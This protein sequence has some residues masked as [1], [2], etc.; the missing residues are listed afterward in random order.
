MIETSTK[1]RRRAL[2]LIL[3]LLAACAFQSSALAQYIQQGPKLVG[4]GAID[5]PDGA[6]QGQA[7]AL[8]A[9]GNT[10]LVGGGWDNNIQGAVWIWTRSGGAWTQQAKLVD[11]AVGTQQGWSAALSADGNTALVGWV[12]DPNGAAY[13]AAQVWTRT[14]SLWTEQG[15][16][17]VGTGMVGRAAQ[18]FSVAL[19]AD[20]NTAIIG[21]VNDNG[22]NDFAFEGNPGA[23]WVFSRSGGVWTQQGPKLV[24]SGAAGASA[25]GASVALSADGNTALVGGPYDDPV[26]GSPTGQIH[27]AVWVWV[28]SGGVWTQEGPKLTGTPAFSTGSFGTAVALSADGNTALVGGPGTDS[29]MGAAFVFTRSGGAWTQQAPLLQG[30]DHAGTSTQGMSVSLSSD[31]NTAIV[32]GQSDNNGVGAAWVFYRYGASWSQQ[33]PKLVGSGSI[34]IPIQGWRVAISGDALTAFV[35]GPWDDPPGDPHHSGK[36]AAWAYVATAPAVTTQPQNQGACSGGPVTFSAVGAS[37]RAMTAQWQVS[38]DGGLSFTDIALPVSGSSVTLSLPA[39]TSVNGNQYRV[40]FTSSLG[41]TTSNPA[42]LSV[43]TAPTVTTNPASQSIATGATV[44]FTAAA[45]STPAPT[46]RWYVSTDGGASYEAIAGATSTTLAFP[47]STA[48]NGNRYFAA[49]TSACSTAATTAALLTVTAAPAAPDITQQPSSVEVCA[50]QAAQGALTQFLQQGGRL[51]GSGSSGGPSQGWAVALSADGSTALVGGNQD[52]Y[53]AGAVWVFTRSGDSWTQQGPKLVASGPASNQGASVALSADGNTA[54]IGS[55]GLAAWVWTRSGGV[56]TQQG[57]PLTGAGMGPN[58][59]VFG[60]AVALSA[61]GNTAAVGGGWGGGWNG[62]VWMFTRSGGVWSP[63]GPLLRG[64]DAVG[65]DAQGTSVALSADGNT[66]VEGGYY[67][68]DGVG[69]A[70]VFTRSGGI[71]AQQG[72]KLVGSGSWGA[73]LSGNQ[74]VRVALSSDGNTALVGAWNEAPPGGAWIWTRSGGVWTQ[75]GPKLVGTGAVGNAHI[76]MSVALSGDGNVALLGGFTDNGSNGAVW[77][78][79][80][81]LGVWTQQGS[82]LVGTGSEIPEFFTP[83]QGTSVALSTD[84]TTAIVGGPGSFDLVHGGTGAAWVFA[85]N[86][87]SFSAAADGFPVPTVQ[88]QV[89]TNGG[90]T[91]TDIPGATSGGLNVT[92]APAVNGNRYRAVF[93]NA[94]GTR[95]SNAATFTVDSSPAVTAQPADQILPVGQTATFAAAASGQPTPTLQ[96]QVSRNGGPFGNVSGA[97]SSPLIVPVTSSHLGDRYRAAFTNSCGTTVSGEALLS[98]QDVLPPYQLFTAATPSAG[99]AVSPPSGGVHDPGA[100]VSLQANPNP[101][102]AFT[103]WTGPVASQTSASTTVTVNGPTTVTATFAPVGSAGLFYPLPPCRVLDTRNQAGPLGAPPLQPNATRSFDVAGV[104]GIPADAVAISA[105]LTVT[106]VGAPGELVVFPADVSRPNTSSISFRAGRTRAN[107]AI[108]ALANA[109]TTF[110]VFNN[111]AATV[112]FIVD[113]NGFFR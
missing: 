74:G 88:W 18:G 43:A 40:V 83:Q 82:K 51:I 27:G 7:V 12:I 20:G 10:A 90:A 106:T 48:M 26:P 113:V 1:S 14:G 23:A 69:A 73:S 107:N 38:T 47:V 96:W 60:R 29:K 103:G 2:F 86:Q 101:G 36:G 75:Q 46:A 59:P 17:L 94:S 5:L 32:G 16:K 61:D 77:V 3:T 57:P 109:S 67:D 62:A 39:S 28:R 41:S 100:I 6:Q 91:F 97:T 92:P 89:S 105:N 81:S 76:G 110:S 72:L 52:G 22:P 85:T 68:N 99:G 44:T 55:F 53:G 33:G 50:G 58:N 80:R 30:E 65:L 71:W 84:G 9:D 25:Q 54:L 42:T 19:S 21:G 79:R 56:W 64:T 37:W 49:F 35:G 104:C 13:G 87:V 24:G 11:P 31:G 15:P 34:G 63:Q 8:S 78:F 93:T 112:D 95:T 111:S 66:L 4:T 70:W 102:F 98:T 108:V 45:T